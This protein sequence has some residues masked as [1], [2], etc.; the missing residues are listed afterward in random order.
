M[1][2]NHNWGNACNLD[3]MLEKLRSD[4]KQVMLAS[5]QSRVALRVF[6]R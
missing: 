1:S 4:L 2:I 3:I 5:S 6:K